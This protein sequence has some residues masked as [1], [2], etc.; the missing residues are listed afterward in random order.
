MGWSLPFRGED[1]A[2]IVDNFMPHGM[3]YLWQ[4]GVL[5]LHVVSD[6]LITLAYFCISFTLAYFVYKREDLQ[7]H[8]MFICFA[9]FIVACG[10][11]HLLEVWVVWHPTYWLSG[12]VKAATA[13]ASVVTAIYLVKLVPQAMQ[14]PSPSALRVSNAELQREIAERKRAE[15]DIRRL[16]EQLEE[17]VA[18]RTRELEAA[19][20]VL[21]QTQLQAMQNERLGALGEMASGIA[22]DINN[23]L[24][25]AA[26][27]S[28]LLLEQNEHLSPEARDY[29]ADIQRSVQDVV[30]T[31]TRLRDFYRARETQSV[32]APVQLNRVVKQVVDL[33]RARWHDVAHERG[34]V[35]HLEMSLEADLPQVLGVESEIR[36][37]LMNLILNAVDAMPEGGTLAIRSYTVEPGQVPA[38]VRVEVCDTGIGMTE[39]T[40]RKCLEPFFTTK[41]ER[42]TGLGLAMVYGMVQRHRADIEIDSAPGKGATV[43][44]IFPGA[45]ATHA[46]ADQHGAPSAPV[47]S[48]PILVVDDDPRILKSLRRIL[49]AD[50]HRV[51]VAD[52]GQAGIDAFIAARRRGEPFALVILDLGMPYVDGRKA[53]ASIKAASPVT[54]IVLVTGWGHGMRVESDLPAHVDRL[55]SKPPDME[56]L[57]K[58]IMKLT[59]A[60][61]SLKPEAVGR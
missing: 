7:F 34:I 36:D 43:S 51:T 5:G 61:G 17:R 44:L 2:M 30:H 37:A 24:S 41:G 20:R 40:R 21:Q 25:P 18:E 54:P 1:G 4:P 8:W 39:E 56:Q 31:V 47:P 59:A 28:R 33:T 15:S 19:N 10:G 52:G 46:P 45:A 48:L 49:E 60:S 57:R 14:L 16:N 27:Y 50:G 26:L 32:A 22:H 58:T 55:L 35:I 42:G 13:L 23:S 6:A 38:R 9:V 12:S 11:T 3:C 53:A 29:L